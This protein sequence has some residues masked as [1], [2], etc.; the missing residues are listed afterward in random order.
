MNKINRFSIFLLLS[1]V[2]TQLQV[3]TEVEK[4][5]LLKMN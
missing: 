2:F 1:Q 3:V 4:Q 5:L